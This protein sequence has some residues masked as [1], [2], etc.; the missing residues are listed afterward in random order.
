MDKKITR[1]QFLIILGSL[2]GIMILSRIPGA[3][4]KAAPIASA[5][6]GAGTYGGKQ[7]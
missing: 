5:G 6:Y 7:A 2:I 1:K 3:S 4:K